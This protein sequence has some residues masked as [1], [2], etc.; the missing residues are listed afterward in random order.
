[1]SKL[2]NATI[3]ELASITRYADMIEAETLPRPRFEDGGIVRR[4]DETEDFVVD[5]YQVYDDGNFTLYDSDGNSRDYTRSQRVRR[6]EIDAP[7]S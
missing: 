7:S 5:F 1:M 3:E 4:G 2:A 6:R